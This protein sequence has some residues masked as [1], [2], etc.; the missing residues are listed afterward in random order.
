MKRSRFLVLILTILALVPCFMNRS[1]E[2]KAFN[3]SASGMCVIEASSHRVL[4]ERNKDAKLPMA[5]TTKVVTALTVLNNCTDLDQVITVDDKAV[6]VSGTS[7]Y[8]RYG[9]Q[10]SIRDLL[11]GLMLRS[12]NDAAT[13]LAIHVGGSVENFAKMMTQTAV[14]CGAVNSHFANPHGLD[15]PEHYTTAYDLA[16]ITAK[17]LEN[18]VFS[19]IVS[20]VNYQIKE[21]E[22]SQIRFLHN[23]NRL[24][25]SLDGCIG[26][27]TGFT[28]K[29]G[30]CLV[31]ATERDGM[32]VVCVVLNC[33][34]MFEESAQLLN[35]AYNDY[36][37]QTIVP[38]NTHLANKTFMDVKNN[39]LYVYCK[40]NIAYPVRAGEN[41]DFDVQYRYL[42]IKPQNDSEIGIVDV[43]CEKHLIKSAKLYTINSIELLQKKDILDSFTRNWV[44]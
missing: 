4:Y 28:N 33:G 18:P 35:S 1:V 13:A 31:S 44:D 42:K 36:S 15:D 34:P 24:L 27:K 32:K 11:Y 39:M 6:G 17:A 2:A 41:L 8:L 26:V 9:E 16:L 37:M 14:D 12:G 5:S 30:R 22:Q 29:A 40:E 21:T 38:A 25:N 19:K 43:F 3:C 20:T 7:I 10:L 23:K